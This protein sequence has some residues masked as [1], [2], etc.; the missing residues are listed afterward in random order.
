MRSLK[1]SNSFRL[2]GLLGAPLV[3]I[4]LLHSGWEFLGNYLAIPAIAGLA[5]IAAS[6]LVMLSDAVPQNIK[7]KLVFLRLKRELPGHRCD[8]LCYS[9]PRFSRAELAALWPNI[10]GATSVPETR[11]GF[12]YSEIYKPVRDSF[13]V[14]SAHRNFLLYRDATAGYFLTFLVLVVWWFFDI[15]LPHLQGIKISDLW[16]ILPFL[17][18]AWAS[19][20]SYGNRMVVNAVLEKVAEES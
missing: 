19:A 7:Q 13:T 3:I 20:R 1:T 10:F 14:Q 12:W 9:D 5:T 18:F 11:N 2:G 4:L 17:F 16:V 6:V 8:K 15:H